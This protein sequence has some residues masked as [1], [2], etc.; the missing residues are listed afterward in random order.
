MDWRVCR[1][2]AEL[3][4]V[5]VRAFA[6]WWR[7]GCGWRAPFGCPFPGV[8]D[9]ERSGPAAGGLVAGDGQAVGGERVC[10]AGAQ[11]VAG[12]GSLGDPHIEIEDG[13]GGGWRV[14]VDG[15]DLAARA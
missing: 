6:G 13:A 14:E 12:V 3:S 7:A 4:W 9:L 2:W 15:D 11:H 10:Q 1:E 8:D 5:L